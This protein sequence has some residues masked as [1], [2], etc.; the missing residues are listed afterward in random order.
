MQ[1]SIPSEVYLCLDQKSVLL[2]QE[3]AKFERLSCSGRIEW[4]KSTAVLKVICFVFKEIKIWQPKSTWFE[5]SGFLDNPWEK[6]PWYLCFLVFS[7]AVVKQNYS[8]KNR[9]CH[10]KCACFY[11]SGR[12]SGSGSLW[13]KPLIIISVTFAFFRL[14]TSSC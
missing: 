11:N 12:P 8:Y 10:H 3:T 2:T 1:M 5:P 9:P 13:K 14:N 6:Q 7:E 4:I